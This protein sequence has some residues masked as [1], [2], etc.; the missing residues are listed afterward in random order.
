MSVNCLRS[1]G[2]QYSIITV[3]IS[4]CEVRF[5]EAFKQNLILDYL[6]VSFLGE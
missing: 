6:P 2:E 4:P 3:V 5:R 1:L